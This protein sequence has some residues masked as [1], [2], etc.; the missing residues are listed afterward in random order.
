MGLIAKS[1]TKKRLEPAALP[2]APSLREANP[3]TTNGGVAAA[4]LVRSALFSYSLLNVKS[5]SLR[6]R[7]SALVGA[8]GP[9]TSSHLWIA[10]VSGREWTVTLG[11]DNAAGAIAADW[12]IR[13]KLTDDQVQVTTSKWLT[14]DDTLVNGILH[15]GLRE[16]LLQ[17]LSTGQ[18]PTPN[19]EARISTKSL[20][21]QVTFL[22]PAPL[23]GTV[24]FAIH[25]TL[26][27]ASCWARL[28]LLG[29]RVL[30]RSD[31][32][33]IWGIGSPATDSTDQVTLTLGVGPIAGSARIG[34]ASPLGLRT[35][36]AGL[37]A[38]IERAVFLLGRDDPE[39]R[40]AGPPEWGNGRQL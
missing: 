2:L 21:I 3:W 12:V 34:S 16:E 31:N 24:D 10:A 32:T 13:V 5:Q 38:F 33:G 7:H 22:S 26:P 28:D 36:E 17:A 20:S 19:L 6:G 11:I 25:T 35:A 4:T 18:V 23:P 30:Q 14:T 27:M 37:K 15:D 8:F 9:A 29:Y 40:Y 39:V 1:K